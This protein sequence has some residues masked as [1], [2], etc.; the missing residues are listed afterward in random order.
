MRNDKRSRFISSHICAGLS[1]L[2][3]ANSLCTATVY[4]DPL[5]MLGIYAGEALA[6]RGGSTG[7]ALPLDRLSVNEI[8]VNSTSENT[9]IKIN[10]APDL[11]KLAENARLDSYTK[12]KTFVLTNDIDLSAYPTFTAIPGFSGLFDGGGHRISG[13]KYGSDGYVSGLFRYVR[14]GAV[15]RDLTVQGSITAVDE[16]KI[17]GGICGINEGIISD[18]TFEGSVNGKT[19]TGGIAAV[20]E[21]PGTI[22]ACSN[23]A[24]VSGY[25]YTGGVTGKNYGVVAYSRNHGAINNTTEWVEGSDAMDPGS[26]IVSSILSGGLKK[27]N[28]ES[29]RTNNGVDTGG[30][31]G[32][33]LGA[34]YQCDNKASVGYEHTGYNVGGI[35]GR[36]AGFVSFC[37]NQGTVYGRKDVGGIVGQMEPHL[38]L[39]ELESLPEAVD[40]LHDLVDT[41]IDDMDSSV[42]VISDDVKLLSAYADNAVSSGDAVMTSGR[43][44]LNQ[45]SDAAN[46]LKARVDYLS[47]KMPKMFEYLDSTNDH[48][49]DTEDDMKK[50]IDDADVY[51]RVT[52]S[53]NKVKNIKKGEEMLSHDSI[54]DKAEGVDRILSEVLPDVRTSLSTISGNAEKVDKSFDKVTDD[55]DDGVHY[56][57]DVIE[58]LNG[59]SKPGAP[60]LGTDFD[61]SRELLRANLDGMADTLSVLADHTDSSSEKVTADM[62]DVNDQIN[63]VFHILSDELDRIGNITRGESDELITDVSEEDIESIEQGRVDHSRNTGIVEGDINIGGIAGSM[64]IDTDDPEENAAGSMDGGFSAKYL[65]RNII[66]DCD[67]DS[68]IKSKKDGVGGIVG[69]M[70]QGIVN[71]CESYG[72][73]TSSE[74]GYVGGIAGQSQSIV[75]DSYSMSCLSGN[76]YIGGIAGFGTTITG[77]SAI[78]S[79]ETTGDRRGSIAGHID[80][81][82]ETHIQH[83]DAV[84]DNR[85][86]NEKVAGIDNLSTAGHAEPVTYNEM[87]STEN[88]PDSFKKLRVIFM[89]DDEVAGS[90]SLPYGTPLKDISYPE[91][92]VEPDKYVSWPYHFDNEILTSPLIIKGEEKDLQK[93]LTSTEVYPGTEMPAALVSGNF[94]S[95]DAL[96]ASVSLPDDITIEYE[97]SY[98]GEHADSVAAT[99]LYTPF[100]KYDLY[101]I[102]SDGSSQ[103]TASDKKGSYAEI[104]GPMKYTKYRIEN[105]SLL[106][107][108]KGSLFGKK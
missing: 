101:G 4:A 41:S 72:S 102:A 64:S 99:R 76:S 82:K 50:L 46:S 6:I 7:T 92:S 22:M 106:D 19:I 32:Y 62:S 34:I 103:K 43:N 30:I 77:C 71:G 87:I 63:V 67:N 98:T 40:R 56:T 73:V 35:V 42:G 16:E 86:V 9:V 79:F 44:Y 83:L 100:T 5:N 54:G 57:K 55:I 89:V 60:Y 51:K 108:V 10:G 23:K 28:D 93:T 94:T 69:Y 90:T 68:Y 53:A 29:I 31:A 33:S 26:D 97:L 3:L 52:A 37:N 12:D 61:Y 49:E 39:S 27:D 85:F 84:S 96:S 107:K 20:N 47:D 25:Y 70:E 105:T 17:T 80:T 95:D 15:I 58:H 104:K 14:Q 66:L 38:T 75:K 36:Q 59:M 45:V 13:L 81:D 74:G 91:P 78:P 2:M 8:S 65:L 48:L 18:C 21:V 1:V 11:L 24:A 88:I